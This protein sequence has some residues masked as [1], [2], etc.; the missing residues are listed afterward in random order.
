MSKE[1]IKIR[2]AIEAIHIKL[3]FLIACQSKVV[4]K[5]NAVGG[6]QKVLIKG[7]DQ[8][9]DWFRK[10]QELLNNHKVSNNKSEN[11]NSEN[12]KGKA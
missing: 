11:A 9:I 6:T 7:E 8:F 5:K 2:K 1:N 4:L 12:S 10:Q 3:D